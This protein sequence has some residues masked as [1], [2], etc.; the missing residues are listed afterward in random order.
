MVAQKHLPVVTTFL[1][2]VFMSIVMSIAMPYVNTGT[3]PIPDVLF[4]I[5]LAIFVSFLAGLLV[6]V[7][8]MGADYAGSLGLPVGSIP[9]IL[10]SSILPTLYFTFIMTFVF[11]LQRT[12]FSS[13]VWQAFMGDIVIALVIAYITTVLATPIVNKLSFAI[14]SK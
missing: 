6:P 11:A 1:F 13:E 9:F 5:I 8:K 3:I 10:V 2:S 7:G 12:G 4:S 14:A